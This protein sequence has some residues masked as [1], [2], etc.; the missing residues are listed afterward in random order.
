MKRSTR[1]A[2]GLLGAAF[3]LFTLVPPATAEKVTFCSSW[4]IYGRDAF[5]VSGVERGITYLIAL[6]P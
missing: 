5:I 3:W 1:I 4:I 2:L 6:I